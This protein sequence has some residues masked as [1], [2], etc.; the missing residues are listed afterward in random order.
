[1]SKQKLI[2]GSTYETREFLGRLVLFLSFFSFVSV[3]TVL[4]CSIVIYFAWFCSVLLGPRLCNGGDPP[5]SYFSRRYLCLTRLGRLDQTFQHAVLAGAPGMAR[6][7]LPRTVVTSGYRVCANA[8]L[9]GLTSGCSRFLGGRKFTPR[10]C[11]KIIVGYS[12]TTWLKDTFS[13]TVWLKGIFSRTIWLKGTFWRTVWTRT[14]SH[15]LFELEHFLMY[16]FT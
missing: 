1:M 2:N 9:E 5:W 7:R 15:V 12:R 6:A 14:L 13:H 3:R 4:F 10:E 16:C 8:A 11:K